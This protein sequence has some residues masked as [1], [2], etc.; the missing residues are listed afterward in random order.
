MAQSREILVDEA[1]DRPRKKAE[2]QESIDIA[3]SEY[4]EER[5]VVKLCHDGSTVKLLR[6]DDLYA[7]STD[8]GWLRQPSLRLE[9]TLPSDFTE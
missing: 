5:V 9:V 6:V 4:A 1:K 7:T 3:M 2:T 8:Y